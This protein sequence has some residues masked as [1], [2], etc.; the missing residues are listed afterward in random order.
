MNIKK[1]LLSLSLVSASTPALH[2][3]KGPEW[4]GQAL[5]YQIYPSS[6]MDTDGNGIGEIPGIISRLDYIQSLGVTALWL[7]PVFECGC[8][9]E[10]KLLQIM[11]RL[12][13]ER[14]VSCRQVEREN[15]PQARQPT[16]WLLINSV[17]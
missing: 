7:N 9:A 10:T 4:L 11:P 15:I 12:G 14:F 16:R 1:V 8:R 2:A 3:Q 17:R 13:P 5:F 6:Y